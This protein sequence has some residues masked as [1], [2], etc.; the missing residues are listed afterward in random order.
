MGF[1]FDTGHGECDDCERLITMNSG[2]GEREAFIHN[3]DFV[4]HRCFIDRRKKEQKAESDK[5]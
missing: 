1:N 5:L 3:G 2:P 4:C